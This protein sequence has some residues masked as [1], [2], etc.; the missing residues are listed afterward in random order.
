M[1]VQHQDG[2]TVIGEAGPRIVELRSGDG[3]H[4]LSA[5]RRIV[6]R[7]ISL[8]LGGY[9]DGNTAVVKLT[10]ESPV[11]SVTVT[12]HPFD[13]CPFNNLTH[14]VRSPAPKLIETIE[15]CRCSLLL[16]GPNSFLR[17]YSSVTWISHHW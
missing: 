15:V 8:V 11:S 13:A 5:C 10:T 9:E 6:A 1:I 14:A 3:E 12:F 2:G 4:L 16:R 7:V 17:S